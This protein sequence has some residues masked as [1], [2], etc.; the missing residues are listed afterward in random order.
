MLLNTVHLVAIA[1]NTKNYLFTLLSQ[2][3]IAILLA[4]LLLSF[5]YKVI[6]FNNYVLVSFL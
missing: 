3:L 1:D 5:L 6:T 2:H 4:V